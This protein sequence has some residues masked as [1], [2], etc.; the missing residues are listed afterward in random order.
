VGTAADPARGIFETLLV[1]GGR[2][3]GL[4]AHLA[5]M[6]RSLRELF[7]A[8]LP[9]A[10]ADDAI[11]AAR[12]LELGRMRIDVTPAADGSLHHEVRAVPIDPAIFFPSRAEGADL[13]PVHPAAW[14]GAHKWADR[15]WLEALEDELGD[16]DVPLI[17]AADDEVLEAGRANVFA[18][19][20][21]ALTTPPVDHRILAG[22]ARA[23]VL[24]LAGDLGIEAAERRLT[25]ADLKEADDVFLTS[26]VR[27]IRPARSLDGTP[28]D[29]AT[30]LTE[31]LADAL[32]AR[33][34]DR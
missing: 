25:L 30:T 17:L 2:P 22:T 6:E 13:R 28:I 29:P 24:A 32:R 5:R 7:G 4:D 23:A 33:W 18:V 19:I 34:L 26:S 3:V 20:D 27:G 11:D 31:R 1:A 8:E 16:H 14:D 9:V 10:I 12:D 15:D 21:G